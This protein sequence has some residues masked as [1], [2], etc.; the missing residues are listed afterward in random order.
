LLHGCDLA[1]SDATQQWLG[2]AGAFYDR[3]NVNMVFEYGGTAANLTLT[4][5]PSRCNPKLCPQ[6]STIT[7]SNSVIWGKQ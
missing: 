1:A 3:W 5:H 4:E 7:F 6:G 2:A